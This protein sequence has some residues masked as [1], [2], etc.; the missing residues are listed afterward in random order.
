MSAPTRSATPTGSLEEVQVQ[1]QGRDWAATE[2]VFDPPWRALPELEQAVSL[3]SHFLHHPMVTGLV[4]LIAHDLPEGRF[5]NPTGRIVPLATLLRE[6][7][8]S[9]SAMGVRA[10]VELAFLVGEILA[11][12]AEVGAMVGVHCH[13]SVSP[14]RIA[15]RPDGDVQLLGHGLPDLAAARLR[16]DPK[17][18]G[19]DATW[20]YA[21]PERFT[22]HPEDVSSDLFSL[23]LVSAEVALGEPI[24]QGTPTELER[25]GRQGLAATLLK[26]RAGKR[27]PVLF[28][29]TLVAALGADKRMRH[30]STALFLAPLAELLEAGLEGP[31][32][33]DVASA[34][35]SASA[36]RGARPLVSRDTT[37]ALV[38]PAQVE[39]ALA[40]EPARGKQGRARL[41]R[42]GVETESSRP[43][44][45]L[46]RQAEP[47]PD[48][49]RRASGKKKT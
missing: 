43:R 39:P 16:R 12:G 24:R 1:W 17:W 6:H 4:P 14:W 29:D 26:R 25:L 9:N 27:L 36:R 11:E 40:P 38:R 7:R 33:T 32:L 47:T 20:L 3:G 49:P 46:P 22:S 21:P 45:A 42:V 5:T 44:R 30:Q 31:G 2:L 34:A 41:S 10:A 37:E 19:A 13:G 23:A 35:L 28:R 48:R 15:V 8:R 18:R